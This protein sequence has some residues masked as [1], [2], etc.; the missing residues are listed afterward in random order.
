MISVGAI[1][2]DSGRICLLLLL[3]L[4]SRNGSIQMAV[5]VV[6]PGL[7]L[8]DMLMLRIVVVVEVIKCWIV[9]KRRLLLLLLVRM[10]M[11][12]SGKVL[13]GGYW[14][15]VVVWGRRCWERRLA[16]TKVE[17]FFGDRGGNVCVRTQLSAA[18]SRRARAS[19]RV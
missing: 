16:S 8:V 17:G 4:R 7:M 9:R 6:R 15:E 2:T 13:L 1:V 3:W 18:N 11:R 12:I 10:R 14:R 19:E 5:M